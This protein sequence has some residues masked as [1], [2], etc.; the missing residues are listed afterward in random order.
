MFTVKMEEACSSKTLLIPLRCPHGF[1]EDQLNLGM[2][3]EAWGGW[4]TRRIFQPFWNY[5]WMNIL[6]LRFDQVKQTLDKVIN[7][8]KQVS[9]NKELRGGP[10]GPQK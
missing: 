9:G 2:C 10:R 3:E 8:H 7:D 1:D 6:G 4:K 5:I